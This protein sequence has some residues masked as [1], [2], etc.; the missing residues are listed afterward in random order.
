VA[1]A[2]IDVRVGPP[3]AA[4]AKSDAAQFPRVNWFGPERRDE[5]RFP[6]A[7]DDPG[8]VIRG[9]QHPATGR[10]V[11]DLLA[12]ERGGDQQPAAGRAIVRV[13]AVQRNYA[14][15][16]RLGE[17]ERGAIGAAEVGAAGEE[18]QPAGGAVRAVHGRTRW[19]FRHK[20]RT[21]GRKKTPPGLAPGRG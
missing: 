20:D 14:L 11:T 12:I 2:A 16:E 10:A 6:A 19:E 7:R 8:K 3:A 18:F 4:R 1:A 21:R 13:R 17:D 9:Q 5:A 15:V